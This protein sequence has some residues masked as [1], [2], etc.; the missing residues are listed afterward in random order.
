[1]RP[2]LRPVEIIR[3][4]SQGELVTVLRDGERIATRAVEVRAPLDHLL[5]LMDGSIEVET[6]LEAGERVGASRQ[7][8]RELLDELEVTA[9]LEGRTATKRRAELVAAFERARVRPAAH[10]GGSYPGSARELSRFIDHRCMAISRPERPSRRLVGLVA[11]HM[12]L[13]RAASG[14]GLA[15]GTL[16]N[17]LMGD[18]RLFVVLGTCHAGL[19]TPF[20]T[21]RK[22]YATPLGTLRVDEAAVDALEARV[23]DDALGDEYKHKGEHSIEFQMVFLAHLLGRER[24]EHV[25]VLPI[26]CGLGRAQ[27]R[28]SDPR[29]DGPAERFLGALEELLASRTDTV[30]VAGADLAHV[31]PRFGD[32]DAL[33]APGRSRLERRDLTTIE[34]LTDRDPRGFFQDATRDLD[35]RR[36][37]GVGPIYTLLRATQ[38]LGAEEAKMLGYAQCVDP[39][40]G[41]VVSYASAAVY[42]G[43]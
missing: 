16:G 12:D 40:E 27:A 20:S 9:M 42:A 14:Y 33:D 31:G 43:E 36:V 41:S 38:A 25:R 29:Q 32:A 11:P 13:Y 7:S 18:E 22:A 23:G 3:V 35:E 8:V 37:C 24:L 15:Y 6:L 21:T 34:R 10:A 26:L 19:R 4:P 17:A 5:A 30:V 28:R 39:E 1:V 2:R